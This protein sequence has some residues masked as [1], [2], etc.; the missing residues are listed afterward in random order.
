MEMRCYGQ[1]IWERAKKSGKG[2]ENSG[3]LRN[4]NRRQTMR[5]TDI[6]I[7]GAGPAGIFT[8]LEMLKQ[9]SK[10]KIVLVDR[11]SVV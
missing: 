1:D 7:I 9:G 11:K 6:C 10:K 5:N 3:N 4:W 8:A 2:T